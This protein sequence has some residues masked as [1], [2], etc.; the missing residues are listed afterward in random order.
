MHKRNENFNVKNSFE[1]TIRLFKL[2]PLSHSVNQLK[3]DDYMIKTEVSESDFQKQN[4]KKIQTEGDYVDISDRLRFKK[5][6]IQR[7][8]TE[9]MTSILIK[10]SSFMTKISLAF[11]NFFIIHIFALILHILMMI[12]Q[13]FFE[14]SCYFQ[15]KQILNLNLG[16]KIFIIIRYILV[17]KFIEIIFMYNQIFHLKVMRKNFFLKIVFLVL[18]LSSSFYSLFSLN[19]DNQMSDGILWMYMAVFAIYCFY[20]LIYFV[21]IK[22]NIK[23]CLKN[24]FKGGFLAIICFLNIVLIRIVFRNL[25]ISLQNHFQDFLIQ[26]LVQLMITFYSIL[27]NCLMQKFLWFYYQLLLKEASNHEEANMKI[28]IQIRFCCI[29]VVAQNILVISR[30]RFEEWGGWILFFNYIIF[31]IYSYTRINVLSIV[32]WKI[33]GFFGKNKKIEIKNEVF[34]NFEK[35]YSGGSLDTQLICFFRLLI[36]LTWKKWSIETSYIDFYKNCN[37]EISEKFTFSLWSFLLIVLI[38]FLILFAV[39]L[40]MK[41]RKHILIFYKVIRNK[42]LNVYIL[43]GLHIQFEAILQMFGFLIFSQDLNFQSV[44][45]LK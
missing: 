8:S 6:Q 15:L 42:F 10:K 5:L 9:L 34:E 30:M 16:I 13:N 18:I 14:N 38:N 31:I 23:L 21:L 33:V 36:L 17:N 40:Y 35:L 24:F 39:L 27:L 7:K 32:F 19:Q 11:N 22:F 44:N 29:F 4:T 28:I 2:K 43:F 3:G 20:Y 12:I 1:K 41:M 26:N 45:N 25:I 37:F